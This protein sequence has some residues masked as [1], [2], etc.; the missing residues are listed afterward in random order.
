VIRI[1]TIARESGSGGRE[2]ARGVAEALGWRLVDR[3]VIDEVARIAKVHPE[4]AQAFDERVNPWLLRLAK[5]LWSGAPD[6]IA[7]PPT[8]EVFDADAMARLSRQVLLDVAGGGECVIVGRGAQCVLRDREDALHV[9]V[10]SP[11]EDRVKRFLARHPGHPDAAAAIAAEDRARFAYV[12]HYYGCDRTRPD[13]YDLLVN[14]RIGID[15]AA[16]LILCAVGRGES[17][18]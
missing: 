2:I 5:G 13:L 6:A 8:G 18:R 9:F 15:R 12:R 17:T 10:F 1:V 4:D 3:V 7:T 16:R 11:C 14:S